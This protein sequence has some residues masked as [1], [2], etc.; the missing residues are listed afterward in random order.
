MINVV[1][2]EEHEPELVQSVCRALFTAYGVGA[3]HTAKLSI[4]ETAVV[5]GGLDAELV[6]QKAESLKI[7]GDDKVLYLVKR[8]FRPRT[9]PVGPVPTHGFA[10]YGKERAAL[11]S[12]LVFQGV[13]TPEAQGARIAKLAVHTVGHLFDLHHCVDNRCAMAVPW[14]QLFIQGQSVE[15]C[16][17]CREK[18]ERS[19]KNDAA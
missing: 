18:S 17:F 8:P 2:L 7:F 14:G 12:A 19:M 15:L 6:V 11:S 3:E 9:S 10:D 1:T 16:N 13:T 4:P 5:E